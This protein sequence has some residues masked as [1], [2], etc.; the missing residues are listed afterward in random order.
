M[1]SVPPSYDDSGGD[2]LYEYNKNRVGLCYSFYSKGQKNKKVEAVKMENKRIPKPFGEIAMEK[3]FITLKQL[4]R[5]LNAQVM[6]NAEKREHRFIGRIL[7]EHGHLSIS[8]R[9]EVLGSLRA[10]HT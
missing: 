3:G 1:E 2:N 4:L 6:D 8:E 10:G 7:L 5:S 9:D